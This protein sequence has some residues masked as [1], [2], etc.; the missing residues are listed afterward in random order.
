MD[1]S[2]ARPRDLD[3]D[4]QKHPYAKSYT[5]SDPESL[6]VSMIHIIFIGQGFFKDT[7]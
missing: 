7:V 2:P 6:K 3:S 1:G 5:V 4:F